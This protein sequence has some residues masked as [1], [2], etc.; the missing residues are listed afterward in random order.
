MTRYCAA[1][2]RQQPVDGQ[3]RA[4]TVEPGRGLLIAELEAA[5]A[6]EYQRPNTVLACGQ[7]SVLTLV[8]RYLQNG[9]FD[10]N[11]PRLNGQPP[12]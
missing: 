3:W 5:G 6:P 11:Q 1:C 7:G 12:A 2:F 8:E 10:H 4:L 9:A